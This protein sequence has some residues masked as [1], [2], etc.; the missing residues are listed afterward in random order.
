MLDKRSASQI[1]DERIDYYQHKHQKAIN[2][3]DEGNNE[4]DEQL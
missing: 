1:R 2:A 3:F 4:G